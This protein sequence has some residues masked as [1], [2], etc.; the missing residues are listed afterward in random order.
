MPR[1][2]AT[3]CLACAL[4]VAAATA[5]R[6]QETPTLLV[7]LTSDDLWTQQ[8]ALEFARNFVSVTGGQLV[9]FLNV[10]AVAIANADVPQHTTALTGKTPR[11]LVEA[12]MADGA[13]VFL[14]GSC[15][16][17]AGLSADDRI[18]GIELA[19]PE[20]HQLLIAPSTKVMSY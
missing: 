4:L 1:H 9:V 8:M 5:P 13:R 6:A 11:E 10:R 16:K 19:S 3:V 20:L 17:Q 18:D 12:L 14:C 7:N 2:L 15:T